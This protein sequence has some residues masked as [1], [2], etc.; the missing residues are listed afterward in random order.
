MKGLIKANFLPDCTISICRGI[1]HSG[2]QLDENDMTW[3]QRLLKAFTKSTKNNTSSRRG[4][5]Q[6]TIPTVKFDS[7]LVTEKIKADLKTNIKLID[8]LDKKYL[9][10]V[11]EA[12]VR[13][14]SAGGDLPVLSTA[15]MECKG[16]SKGR[17]GEI[18]RFLNN[19][20]MSL[21]SRER[22][23]MLGIT[24]AVWMYANAP[25]MVTPKAPTDR[26]IQQDAAHC[27]ANGTRYEISKGLLLDG[28][29]TWPG[30]EAGC[31]CTS[32]VVLPY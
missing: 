18:A 30:V 2:S 6:H 9:E 13:A 15:L 10:P 20:A 5:A 3:I 8:D 16:M 21:I 22:Q 25:C 24:H 29:W 26:D 1:I 4:P 27:G 17:A 14:I 32:R 19:R 12:A 11:Y 7:S 28:K 31:K 23:R